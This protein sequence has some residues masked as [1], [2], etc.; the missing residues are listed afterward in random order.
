MQLL[1]YNQPFVAHAGE[2][3]EVKVSTTLPSFT[4]EAVRLGDA[5]AR[6]ADPQPVEGTYPGRDQELRA[7]SYLAAPVRGAPLTGGHSVQLWFYPTLLTERRTLIAGFGPGGGWEVAVA[8]DRRLSAAL[9]SCDGDVRSEACAGPVVA[10]RQ[11]YFAAVSWHADGSVTLALAPRDPR[12]PE[13]KP[14]TDG[15][16][17]LGGPCPSATRVTVG[18]AVPDNRPLRCFDGK[19][20]SPRLFAGPLSPEQLG[21]LAADAPPARVGALRHEWLLGP[22]AALPPH[23][24]RDAGPG[25]CDGVLVNMP[26]LGVTGR[27]WTPAT[28]SFN[29]AP[30]EYQAAHFHC[31]DLSDAGWEASLRFT[32]P[33]KWDS[34]VYGIRLRAADQ[35]GEHEDVA[36]LIVSAT[37]KSPADRPSVA[38]L[39]PT[40]SY[41]AY[42]NEH[43]SWERP[44]KSSLDGISTMVVSE[45][46]RYLAR[47]RLLS[48]YDLHADGSG[49]CLSS[50]RRPVLNMRPGYRMP[51]VAGPHQFSADLELLAWLD[52]RGVDYDVITDD[53]LH[54]HGLATVEPYRVVLTGSHPEY[55]STQMLD[56]LDAY[57]SCGGCLM[58]LGGNGFYWVTSAPASDPW[59]I[60]VRRGMAGSRVWE[61]LPGEWHQAMTGEHGGIW[62]H[63]GR[64]P[65]LLTG[66]GYTSQGFDKSLDYDVCIAPDDERAGWILDG[67]D[68]QAPLGGAGSVLGGPAGF[69]IDRA[70]PAQGTPPG[71]VLVASARGFSDAYQGAVEDVTT[72]DS[73]QGGSVCELVRSDVVFFETPAAGAVFSVGSIAWCGALRDPQSGQE[74]PVGRMTW[75]V[76]TRF[77]DSRPFTAPGKTAAR[78]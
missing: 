4:A 24:V 34:G 3:V 53:D 30:G 71:A 40:F 62:R 41:L 69:E 18:A 67:I 1:G 31:D 43:A 57:M 21:A 66:V 63:R 32:V 46:D 59:A 55:V 39:L 48:L 37:G 27:N 25:R 56:G 35:D 9:L 45:L 72:A 2:T 47:H 17:G 22:A 49:T 52:S 61:S 28:E 73:L 23:R 74:T 64:A 15:Q 16:H 60:E 7:G 76:L 77:S 65:Q 19:I 36:P 75:N 68:P 70:D 14:V 54:Q 11:W 38:V 6:P 8:D 50:W 78:R 10:E 51:L 5:E 58:Y 29:A 13:A 44:I 26:A 20:D 33:A 12:R 42:A